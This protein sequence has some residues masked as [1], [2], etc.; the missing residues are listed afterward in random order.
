[1]DLGLRGHG[2]LVTG[3]SRGIGR[4]TALCFAH[5]GARV[6][7]TYASGRDEAEAVACEIGAVGVE[8]VA[9]R[10]D[11]AERDSIEAAVANAATRFGGLDVVVANAVRWPI[12]ASGPLHEVAVD[13]WEEAVSVNL[14]GTASTL[15]AA[16]PYLADSD[17]GRAVIISSGVS[18]SGRAGETAYA[19]AKAALDGLLAALKWEAG[20]AGVLVNIVAPGFTLTEHNFARFGDEVRESV[21]A[22]TPSRKLSTPEDV[23]AAVVFL[24]SPANRNIAG[25]YL[26]VAGGID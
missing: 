19:T 15:R 2:V 22:Q 25:T 18:R 14:A 10:L 8:G 20:E 9:V 16:L 12:E 4:A 3:G 23:A 11:L 17:A 6:A 13:T 21:A 7:L 26:P 1:M 24:G 5:E